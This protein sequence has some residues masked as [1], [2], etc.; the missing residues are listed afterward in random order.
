MI[1]RGGRLRGHAGA[2]GALALLVVAL[3]TGRPAAAVGDGDGFVATLWGDWSLAAAV[4]SNELA[5]AAGARQVAYLVHLRQ[6]NRR[7]NEVRWHGTS[8]AATPFDQAPLH[9]TLTAAVA[10]AR[11]RGLGVTLVPF[12]MADS[13]EHRQWF[14]PSDRDAWFQSYTDHVVQL[15]RFAEAAGASEMLVGSELTFL[16]WD[17][18]GWR[19]TIAAVRSAF[20][21]HLTI[22]T[23]FWEYATIRF[24]DALDSVGVSGYFPLAFWTLTRSPGSLERMWRFHKAHLTAFAR[25]VGKPL[26][27]SE[28]GYPATEVAALMPWDYRWAERRLDPQLQARCFEAFRRVWGRE[29]LLR[30]FMIWGLGPPAED[31]RLTGG[32][33]FSPFGKPAEAEVRALLQERSAP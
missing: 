27:L 19:G 3:G 8:T 18:A 10:D 17:E 28:V 11:A 13:G 16:Y 20:S 1:A 9:G 15:A 23:L 33:G 24:W 26:T 2:I 32:K 14:W 31:Q 29:P 25:A 30:R 5:E 22:S 21:G 6:G 7:S 4:E 12:I